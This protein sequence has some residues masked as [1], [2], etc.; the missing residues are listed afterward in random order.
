MKLKMEN[1]KVTVFE[2]RVFAEYSFTEF[3][4]NLRKTITPKGMFTIPGCVYTILNGDYS[5]YVKE[6]SP[7]IWSI[8]YQPRNVL[9]PNRPLINDC[10]YFKLSYPY[11]YL[12]I[13]AYKNKTLEKLSAFMSKE[14]I[15]SEE[16]T[17]YSPFITNMFYA[18]CIGHICVGSMRITNPKNIGDLLNQVADEYFLTPGNNDLSVPIPKEVVSRVDDNYI[19]VDNET[20]SNGPYELTNFFTNHEGQLLKS[21]EAYEKMSEEDPLVGLKVTFPFERKFGDWIYGYAK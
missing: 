19:R 15:R 18:I 10:Y 2:E 1:G 21:F 7:K 9:I 14:P 5:I 13:T 3:Y 17:I 4:D 6:F 12:V 11:F 20:Y 16:D 8:A